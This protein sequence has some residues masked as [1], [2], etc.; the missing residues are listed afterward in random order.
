MDQ[1]GF[2]LIEILVAVAVASLLLLAIYGSFGPLTEARNRIEVE[3]TGYHEARVFYDRVG[4]ELRS[5]ILSG[6]S[7][8]NGPQTNLLQG[9]EDEQGQPYLELLS[10]AATPMGGAP[11]GVARIRYL[12]APDQ[13]E[14]A[15][16]LSLYRSEQ[17]RWTT[18]DTG[19]GQRLIPGVT[20]LELRFYDGT[21][22][23]DSWLDKGAALPTRVEI[24]LRMTMGDE[25]VPFRTVFD[26]EH[27]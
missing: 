12:L 9:G 16:V 6:A 2:T 8:N 20:A 24:V 13:D 10:T 18:P 3:S 5:I 27:S 15:G 17:P 26:L 4:R 25:E 7:W 19:P 21:V 23:S 11:G 14:P 22:W 1:R